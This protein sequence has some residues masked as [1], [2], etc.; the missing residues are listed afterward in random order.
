MDGNLLIGTL[1]AVLFSPPPT[2]VGAYAA[3]DGPTGGTR[4]AWH[5]VGPL[6][7]RCSPLLR[8]EMAGSV[9]DSPWGC[10]WGQPP[11]PLS[12][13][14]GRND[15]GAPGGFAAEA[16]PWTPCLVR[17]RED[18]PPGARDV[19][20]STSH[21]LHP[22]LAG[23]GSEGVGRLPCCPPAPLHPVVSTSMPAAAEPCRTSKPS[24]TPGGRIPQTSLRTLGHSISKFSV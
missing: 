8:W 1:Q 10:R 3:L 15:L 24:F 12:I 19:G 9:Q 2:P 14:L 13:A 20:S 7:G 23:G 22:Q 21:S 6:S 17:R 16:P 11:P 4:S 5:P 18:I